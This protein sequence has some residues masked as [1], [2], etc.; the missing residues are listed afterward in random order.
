M[1]DNFGSLF[2][3]PFSVGN[4]A[5]CSRRKCQMDRSPVGSP[6]LPDEQPAFFERTDGHGDM[7]LC[8]RPLFDDLR[9]GITFRIVGEK[10]QDVELHLG[11]S[12]FL[13]D[14]I[15]EIIVKH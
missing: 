8:E 9:G 13:T 11:Q 12:I 6:V 14:R 2:L 5:G 4:Y 1:A 15:D 3:D 10:Q 7:G